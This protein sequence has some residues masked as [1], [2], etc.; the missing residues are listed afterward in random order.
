[1]HYK[2][3]KKIYRE[4]NLLRHVHEKLKYI[5]FIEVRYFRDKISSS[6]EMY[7]KMTFQFSS[8]SQKKYPYKKFY[9]F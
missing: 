5:F 6:L 9:K 8:K 2:L 3:K 7:M 4:K 1:M